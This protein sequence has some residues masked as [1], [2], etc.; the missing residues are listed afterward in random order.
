MEERTE[1]RPTELAELAIEWWCPGRH[2]EIYGDLVSRFASI[3][4]AYDAQDFSTYYNLLN[5]VAI[6]VLGYDTVAEEEAL[7]GH[8]EDLCRGYFDSC[9]QR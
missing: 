9:E 3:L 8:L 7:L 1:L 5:S 6:N 4:D 2:V